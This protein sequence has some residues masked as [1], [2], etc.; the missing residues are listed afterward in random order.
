MITKKQLQ[1]SFQVYTEQIPRMFES[2]AYWALLHYI[3]IFPDICGALES[4]DGQATSD[5]YK[6][7]ARRYLEVPMFRADEWWEIRCILLHQG[8]TLGRMR[9][10]SYQFISEPDKNGNVFHRNVIGDGQRNSLVL[11]VGELAREVLDALNRWFDDIANGT[12]QAKTN[13]VETN[14]TSLSKTQTS[15]QA[16]SP[17]V[18]GLSATISASTSS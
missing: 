15:N 11:D 2:S 5:R 18:S 6:D 12:D 9:Y 3:I 13:N 10:S 14:I 17:H 8:I 4:D 16:L 7:W 1:E